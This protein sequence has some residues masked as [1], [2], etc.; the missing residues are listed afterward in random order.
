MKQG[1]NSTA[2]DYQLVT[3]HPLMD[4]MKARKL[5]KSIPINPD[6]DL[7]DTALHCPNVMKTCLTKPSHRLCLVLSR[8]ESLYRIAAM[9][10]IMNGISIAMKLNS[11][12]LIAL[13]SFQILSGLILQLHQPRAFVET[14]SLGLIRI[15]PTT[16][17][18]LSLL[19]PS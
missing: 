12:R 10:K 8:L 11:P 6:Q 14:A 3:K 7:G 9:Y 2:R 19:R 18:T 5:L 1:V 4:S 16:W 17:P 13:L 15:S